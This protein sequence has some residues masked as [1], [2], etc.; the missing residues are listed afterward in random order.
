MHTIEASVL[1]PLGLGL[2]SLMLM[3][4][5]FL[6]DQT[7]L[8]AEYA[9]TVLEWQMCPGAWDEDE[10]AE[11]SGQWNNGLLIT[12]VHA[13]SFS[14][15]KTVYYLQPVEEYQ[16]FDSALNLLEQS[17]SNEQQKPVKAALKINPCWLK[18]VWEV[19]TAG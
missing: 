12:S 16:L 8:T 5:F 2:I 19:V 1:V 18:R 6:H 11:E 13:Q 17:F 3:L 9:S 10:C 7:V 14:A 4:A 15:G